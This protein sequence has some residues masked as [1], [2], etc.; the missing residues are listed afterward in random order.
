MERRRLGACAGSPWRPPN[1]NRVAAAMNERR[2]RG[3]PAAER[4]ALGW[5]PRDRSWLGMGVV[6][7]PTSTRRSKSPRMPPE[8]RG[9]AS[10]GRC[11]EGIYRIKLPTGYSRAAL[12]LGC[13]NLSG[14]MPLAR[15]APTEP[16]RSSAIAA[17]ATIPAA[18]SRGALSTS[19]RAKTKALLSSQPPSVRLSGRAPLFQAGTPLRLTGDPSGRI[20][21]IREHRSAGAAT[22]AARSAGRRRGAESRSLV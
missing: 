16:A 9:F 19:W 20:F 7:V 14:A 1:A 8:P 12:I 4:A 22:T 3:P 5:A 2:R 13:S 11:P 18:W 15:E 17:S 10:I 21:D 6:R